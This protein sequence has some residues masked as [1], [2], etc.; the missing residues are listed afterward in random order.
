MVKYTYANKGY[1]WT[2]TALGCE[3]PRIRR[4]FELDYPGRALNLKVV[5]TSWV[6]KGWVKEAKA[7]NGKKQS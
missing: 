7:S 3:Q 4:K 1:E 2:L 6:D 5:P